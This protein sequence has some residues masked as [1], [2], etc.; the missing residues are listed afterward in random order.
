MSAPLASAPALGPPPGMMG[1]PGMGMPG[2]MVAPGAYEPLAPPPGVVLPMLEAE[3]AEPEPPAVGL[4]KRVEWYNSYQDTKQDEM[5]EQRESRRYYHTDQLSDEQKRVLSDRNQPPV[6]NNYIAPMIDGTIGVIIRLRQDPKAFPRKQQ[7]VGGAWI[8][9]AAVREV[10]DEHGWNTLQTEIAHEMAVVGVSGIERLLDQD[11]KDG[12]ILTGPRKVDSETFFYDPRSVQPDFSD[13]RFMGVY[14]WMDLDAAI[15]MMPDRE[16]DLTAAVERGIDVA[17]GLQDWDKLWYDNRLDRV[18]LVECWYKYRGEWHFAV[19]TGDLDLKWGPSPFK[20][21]KGGSACRYVMGTANIDHEGVR[22]G[23]IR[24]M[25]SKQDSVNHMESKLLHALNVRR[26]LLELGALQSDDKEAIDNF[27]RESVKAD[28]V[29]ILA[30]GGLNKIKEDAGGLQIEG[31]VRLLNDAK[32]DIQKF[33]PSPALLGASGSDASGRAIALQQQAGLAQLGPYFTRYKD[34]KLRVYR[35]V[36]CDVKTFWTNPRFIRVAEDDD[37]KFLPVNQLTM[38]PEGPRIA[39]AI[40]DLDIDIVMDEGPDTITLQED[41]LQLIKSLI[42][43]K[44]IPIEAAMPMVMELI[45]IAPSIKQRVIAMINK[46]PDPQQAQEAQ[47]AKQLQV[48]GA[49]AKIRQTNAQ[50]DSAQADAIHKVAQAKNSTALVDEHQV[51]TAEALANLDH[52]RA[53]TRHVE[54]QTSRVHADTTGSHIETMGR[55]GEMMQPVPAY[56]PPVP[57]A[58]P[59]P[60]QAAF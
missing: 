37:I 46:Q 51:H 9:T 42:D 20:D 14:K 8:G 1:P 50:A 44:A 53:Q 7:F 3:E 12:T 13:A 27:R 48:A 30:P 55:L 25:E 60:Q 24:N 26:W 41:A 38:T 59:A 6:E 35:A 10:L 33:G 57:V 28:G 2:P 31:F 21:A 47:I 52:K 15:E 11:P 40:G 16:E 54:A 58:A 4:S 49:Q 23:L 29:M 18:K 17:S 34:W 43:E 56:P 22:Y 45:Q 39:N 32:Q 19:H 36:W 5:D